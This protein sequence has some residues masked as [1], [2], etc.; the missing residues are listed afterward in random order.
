MEGQEKRGNDTGREVHVRDE[1]R[2]GSHSGENERQAKIISMSQK[3]HQAA[4]A[5]V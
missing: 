3:T 4:H 2:C 5:K 1:T